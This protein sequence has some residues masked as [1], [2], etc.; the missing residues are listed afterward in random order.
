MNL[1][2]YCR[3]V[4]ALLLMASLS[5][6]QSM[7]YSAMEKVGF[8][9]RDILVDRVEEARD[10]QEDAKETFKSA[11]ERYQ[12][13]VA[14]DKSDL[15]DKYDKI[16][17]AFE[18]SKAAAEEVTERIEAIE[19]VA[20]AL[21][22]EWQDELS[23]YSSAD[24]R[25]QSQA[26]LSATKKRYGQLMQAMRRAEQKMKPVLSALQDQTLY[27]KHNLNA[28]AIAALKGELASIQTDVG[29]L[30]REMEKS[31]QESEAFIAQLEQS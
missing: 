27:L 17:A 21:F 11:L 12:S 15:Q 26:K 9:K 4:A 29:R 24:L 20:E 30:I 16:N 1:N 23:L 31:I 22:D 5:A 25:R 6:C 7:Y 8:H 18:D 14:T 10:S 28:Q 2:P 3:F 13:V 19:D